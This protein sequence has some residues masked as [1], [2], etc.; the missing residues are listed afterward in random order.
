MRPRTPEARISPKVIIW[1][2]VSDMGPM[3]KKRSESFLSALIN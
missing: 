1:R 3:I 2:E